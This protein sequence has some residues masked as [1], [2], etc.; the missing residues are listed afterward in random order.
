MKYTEAAFRAIEHDMIAFVSEHHKNQTYSLDRPYTFHL[1]AVRDTV[2]KFLAYIPYGVSVEVVVLAAWGHDLIE[3]TGV[4]RE[5]LE[6]RYGSEVSD[7]I[8]RV[9]NEAGI[10]RK[11]RHDATYGK[12]KECDTAVFLKLCDRI[13]NVEA[14]GKT[15]MYKKEWLGF[16]AALYT[17]GE[18]EVLWAALEQ[19]LNGE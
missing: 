6:N 19:L 16:K 7:L 18:F 14:G 1:R 3:D 13:A 4:S 5:E 9:S 12:I 2:F 8:W 10:N 15:G 11:A 17:E